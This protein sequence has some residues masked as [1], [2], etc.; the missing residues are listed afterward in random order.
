MATPS[1]KTRV[2]PCLVGPRELDDRGCIYGSRAG[3]RLTFTTARRPRSL[4][5][6]K[7]R[8]PRGSGLGALRF[9]LGERSD[10]RAPYRLDVAAP[11]QDAWY[12][13]AE[14]AVA[15]ISARAGTVRITGFEG[16]ALFC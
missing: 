14:V 9:V 3:F 10:R 13:P 12:D 4:S 15:R 6:L 5:V 16:R 2:R 11:G 1:S 7:L 8:P